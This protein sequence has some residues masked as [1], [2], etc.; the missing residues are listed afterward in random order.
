MPEEASKRIKREI[1]T[2]KAMFTIYCKYHHTAGTQ[3]CEECTSI[4]EYAVAR[5]H[6]CPFQDLKTHLRQVPD[7]LL[8][9]GYATKDSNC[10]AIFRA[11]TATGASDSCPVSYIR[12]QNTTAATA[13]KKS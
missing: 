10:Y 2:V 5:L 4:Y 13:K 6:R 7:T 9:Q 11:Q 1:K 3:L 8:Q 12:F